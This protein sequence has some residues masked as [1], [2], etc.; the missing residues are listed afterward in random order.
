MRICSERVWLHQPAASGRDGKSLCR[1]SSQVCHQRGRHLW[2]WVTPSFKRHLGEVGWITLMESLPLSADCKRSTSNVFDCLLKFYTPKIWVWWN[3][4]RK[5][6][7]CPYRYQGCSAGKQR[8]PL[9]YRSGLLH[10]A[11]FRVKKP[12]STNRICACGYLVCLDF[13]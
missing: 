6:A 7:Y 5:T 2:D 3:N 4:S 10:P 8:T 12:N 1:R 9:C 11:I 13:E